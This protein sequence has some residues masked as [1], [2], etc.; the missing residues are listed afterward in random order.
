[1]V[2][3]SGLLK[4]QE[5]VLAIHCG[6]QGTSGKSANNQPACLHTPVE[7]SAPQQRRGKI[8]ISSFKKAGERPLH[9]ISEG[10]GCIST[11]KLN[12]LARLLSAEDDEHGVANDLPWPSKGYV[13]HLSHYAAME[14]FLL[15]GI[16]QA[17][18]RE[19]FF[20]ADVCFPGAG[21]AYWHSLFLEYSLSLS[22]RCVSSP[23]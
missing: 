9:H 17:Y 8:H 18:T 19:R 11:S 14:S 21:Y 3:G 20:S 6:L 5:T 10:K 1:M 22:M 15:G 13:E 7:C 2:T 16:W 4:G 23:A 12:A